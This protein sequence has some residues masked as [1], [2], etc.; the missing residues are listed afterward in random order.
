MAEFANKLVQ[1][2]FQPALP[3]RDVDAHKAQLGNVALIGGDTGMVGAL[4]LA[5]RAALLVGAGRIYAAA[6]AGNAPAVDILHPEIMLRS[7]AD[8]AN[9]AQLDCLVIGPGLGQ[10]D[11][12]FELLK[13]WIQHDVTLLLDADALNLVA[14]HADLAA[15]LQK[16]KAETIITPHVGEAAR[17]LN[18]SSAEIQEDRPQTALKLARMFKAS[19]VLKG[20]G[21]ICA[22]HDGQWFVNTTGNPGLAHGGTGDVLSGIVGG[23]VAQGVSSFEALKL[24]VFVH[25]AAADVLVAKGIGPV[26]LT[27]SE[28][29]VEARNVLNR[30]NATS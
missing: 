4:L 23:L 17:L 5:S 6:L 19:C 12:A 27:A 2:M 16:R 13:F 29:A 24:G 14:K 8:I 20:A 21:S 11:V 26:G 18:C 9:L 22:H 25:G 28:V 10:G 15:S 1:S 30:L 7:T 3:V